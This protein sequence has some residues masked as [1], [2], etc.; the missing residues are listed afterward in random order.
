MV[1]SAGLQRETRSI[2]ELE[3]LSRRTRRLILESVHTA[4]AGHIG[5]PLSVTDLLVSLYFTELR[6]DPGDPVNQLRDRIILSKGH[7]SIALYTVMA[8]R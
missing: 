1:L 2:P 6:V 8:L 3:A 5:G 4:G 7:S